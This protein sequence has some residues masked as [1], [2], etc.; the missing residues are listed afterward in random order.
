M[1]SRVVPQGRCSGCERL[2]NPGRLAELKQD[3]DVQVWLHFHGSLRAGYRREGRSV[4]DV[5]AEK[6][7]SDEQL[8][9]SIAEKGDKQIVVIMPQGS[10]AS[11]PD[12]GDAVTD[13]GAYVKRVLGILEKDT[14]IK[15][16]S[17]GLV[18]TG[19]SLGGTAPVHR[20]NPGPGTDR[21][22]RS[23]TTG[24]NRRSRA[25]TRHCRRSPGQGPAAGCS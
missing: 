23:R 13:P 17:K 14:G 19:W 7:R 15:I 8:S 21:L 9:K 24:A 4:R 12:F 11:T 1:L 3:S 20:V 5:D 6:D 22:R 10:F 25:S 2:R 16:R 18:L